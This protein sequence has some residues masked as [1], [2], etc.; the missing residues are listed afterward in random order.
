[1][2]GKSLLK[3]NIKIFN[4]I[5]YYAIQNNELF[6]FPADGVRMLKIYLLTMCCI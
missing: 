1:M 2:N 3:E 5:I 6:I 4:K